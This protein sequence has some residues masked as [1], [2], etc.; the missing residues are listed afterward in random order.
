MLTYVGL[1]WVLLS[2]THL[3]APSQTSPPG[4]VIEDGLR[5]CAAASCTGALLCEVLQLPLGK[6]P[7][8]AFHGRLP[9]HPGARRDAAGAA[10]LSMSGCMRWPGSCLES[11]WTSSC[12]ATSIYFLKLNP[13]VL[14]TCTEDCMWFFSTVWCFVWGCLVSALKL[15]GV[16]YLLSISLNF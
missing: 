14:H 2:N 7:K 15:I 1:F 12:S 3:I 9:G 16:H 8:G 6:L 5:S 11:L 13:S 10:V 4:E